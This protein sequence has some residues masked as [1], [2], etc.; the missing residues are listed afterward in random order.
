MCAAAVPSLSAPLLS[1]IARTLR[2]GK[3]ARQLQVAQA[4]PPDLKALMPVLCLDRTTQGGN[5]TVGECR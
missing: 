2:I 5:S 3:L 1:D 4:A